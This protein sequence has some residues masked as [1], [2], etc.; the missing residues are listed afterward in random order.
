MLQY[1]NGI[2]YRTVYNNKCYA[3]EQL[4][5]GAKAGLTDPSPKDIPDSVL[6]KHYQQVVE[7]LKTFVFIK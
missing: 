7:I 5:T 6:A 2:S 3:L 1:V 4:Q